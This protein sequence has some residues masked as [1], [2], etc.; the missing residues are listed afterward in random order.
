LVVPSAAGGS[1]DLIPRLCAPFLAQRLGQPVIVENIPGGGGRVGALQVA[2]AI[3]DGTTLCVANVSTFAVYPALAL[4]PAY[5][6]L[7]DFSLVSTLVDVPTVLCA[8]PA[9]IESTVAAFLRRARAQS[10]DITFASPGIGSLG[11]LLGLALNRR[12][13]AQLR[14]IPY[15]GAG[16]ALQDVVAGHVGILFDNIPASLGHIK[17][18]RLRALAVSSPRRLSVMP[19]VPTFDEA[20][21]PGL[22]HLAWFGLAAPA[23]CRHVDSRSSWM[24]SPRLWSIHS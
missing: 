6:P 12:V 18:G 15:R 1:G 16:P 22:S 7:R 23:G 14:H 3:P 20:G 11:H 10:T 9:V 19:E 5:Q 21:L 8:G 4:S 13:G 17:A 2:K 24:Q